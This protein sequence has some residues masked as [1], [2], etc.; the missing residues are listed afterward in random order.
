[1]RGSIPQRPT[2]VPVA[3]LLRFD[4]QYLRFESQER[5]EDNASRLGIFHIAYRVRDAHA[6]RIHDSN[7]INRLIQ[8]FRDHLH[9]PDALENPQNRRAI[10]WFKETA[11]E[12]T[13]RIWAMV[14]ILKDYGYWID[15][16]TT[17]NPGQ[18]VYED[19]WQVAAIPR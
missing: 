12:P 3:C 15:L 1:M 16:R 6:T 14:P 18:I 9:A 5:C 13:N 8:W 10:C 7:E 11:H 17:R 2:R 19:D 4:M